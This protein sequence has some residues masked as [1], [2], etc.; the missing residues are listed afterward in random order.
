MYICLCSG[1]TDSEIKEAYI[2]GKTTF[3]DLTK[4][5]NICGDCGKCKDEINQCINLME[6]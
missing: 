1:V 6:K 5:L 3:K 2:N 4:E